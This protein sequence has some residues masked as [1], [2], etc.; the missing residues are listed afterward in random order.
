MPK[1]RTGYVYEE[2]QWLA[3]FYYT[4]EEGKQHVVKQEAKD[5]S[6]KTQ[7]VTFLKKLIREFKNRGE[8]LIDGEQVYQEK[9]WFARFDYTDKNGK[10]RT[11]RRR[12]ENKTHAKELLLDLLQ[13]HKEQS[14]QMLE[15]ERMTFDALA[16]YYERTYL[17]EPE[18]VGDRKVAGLRS[19]YDF[20]LRLKVL[21]EFFGKR[22]L[23]S[24]THGDLERYKAARL[25]VPAVVGRNTRRTKSKGKPK[26]RQRSI[27]TVHRELSLLRR[28]LNV[29]VRNGW[30]VKN[31]FDMGDALIR[32]GDEKPRERILSREEE[33]RLLA[34]CT[35]MREHVRAIIICALDTGMRRG[36]L[37]KLTWNDVDFDN[38]IITVRAF[39]TK[40]LRERQV[41]MTER[42]AR[43]LQVR[44]DLSTKEMDSLV[45]GITTNA[46][47]AFEGA[48]KLAGLPDLRFHDLRHTHATRLVSAHIPLSEV[49]R[50]LGH[51]QPATT[52]RYVNANVD[53]VRRVAAALDA[54]N[55]AKNE[56]ES[57]AVN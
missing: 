33:A 2:R 38:R 4:D 27:A 25:K 50:V 5:A 21:K 45:F 29:A 40:T 44:Y 54:F 36:E 46:S 11:V 34:A 10:R 32:P 42:L 39:N 37:F 26:E 18:Y 14:E 22:K 49:G 51:T 48:R 1:I 15:G 28:V 7:A 19:A 24:I 20:R 53:T 35:G 41:A 43:E 55:E 57:N 3:C 9:R 16:A 12:A 13:K 30:L 6:S 52:Y 47:S 56:S 17:I 8:R 23:P 31:P